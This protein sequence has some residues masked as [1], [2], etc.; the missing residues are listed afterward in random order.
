MQRARI[1]V[2]EDE[3]IV[4][5]DLQDRL[6]GLGYEVTALVHSGVK[7]ESKALAT[8]PD[9]VLMDIMLSDSVDGV[10]AA[11]RIQQNLDIP[12]VYLTAHGDEATLQ[13]AKI[14]APFGYILK[15]FEERELRTAIEIALY[16]HKTEGRIKQ[17]ER[18]L[19]AVFCGIS[20]AV[21]VTD[22]FGLIASMNPAATRL[23]GWP[24]SEASNR[25]LSEIFQLYDRATR[26]PV[27]APLG[28]ILFEEIAINWHNPML[29][30]SRDAREILVDYSA[31]P[32]RNELDDVTG[33]VLVFRDVDSYNSGS[34]RNPAG[35]PAGS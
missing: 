2:V 20:D 26:E 28:K 16:R 21:V 9:L 22:K 25:P 34:Q 17:L 3:A 33:V 23:S 4:A 27:V 29:L 11:R 32:V 13:R 31:A 6:K 8:K 10:E 12:I 24:Q 35:L 14:T 19:E 7:A 18:W 15:P 5:A 1:M 30:T